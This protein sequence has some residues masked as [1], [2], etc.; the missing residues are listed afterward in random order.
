MYTQEHERCSALQFVVVCCC[1][2]CREC[3]LSWC[4]QVHVLRWLTIQSRA[5]EDTTRDT[6]NR[7][8]PHTHLIR[9]SKRMFDQVHHVF[10]QVFW[11]LVYT[12]THTHTH[13]Y[14]YIYIYV[15]ICM[16]VYTHTYMYICIY[17]YI[18]IYKYIYIRI[19]IYIHMDIC[20]YNIYKHIHIYIYT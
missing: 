3:L 13:I 17:V 10:D 14:M 11:L 8:K 12:H 19:Y 20:I 4:V 6:T 7:I 16:N 18:Y 5:F 15:H 1:V 9:T 2:R